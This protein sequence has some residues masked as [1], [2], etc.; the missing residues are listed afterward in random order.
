MKQRQGLK[1]ACLTEIVWHISR[2][3]V[4]RPEA[5]AQP[6]LKNGYHQHLTHYLKGIMQ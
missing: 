5:L 2:I 4:S 1:I 3:D 6:L